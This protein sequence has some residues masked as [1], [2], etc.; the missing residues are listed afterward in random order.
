[1][2]KYVPDRVYIPES[3]PIKKKHEG[4]IKEVTWFGY[5][6][7]A[8]YLYNTFDE[9]IN[10]GIRLTFISNEIIELPL[11]YRGRLKVNNVAYSY[12]SLNRRLI[13]SD[14]IL[15]P[16]PHGD[17]KAQYKSNNKT[18]HAWSI[19]MPVIKVPNDIKRLNDPIERQ[20]ESEKNL[21]EIKDKWDVKISVDEMKLLIKE[22][23]EKKK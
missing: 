16:E 8:Q 21:Q 6:H 11:S 20:K 13:A 22:I 1:L 10:R 7:N 18:L 4:Q 9:L 2:V 19:G 15:M 23:K 17:L 14:A 3:V 12:E 5:S